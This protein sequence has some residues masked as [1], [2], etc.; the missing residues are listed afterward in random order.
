MAIAEL[1][2]ID[3][4][5]THPSSEKPCCAPN[6]VVITLSTTVAIPDYTRYYKSPILEF[7]PAYM[8]YNDGSL[9]LQPLV[10]AHHDSLLSILMT[11]VLVTLFVRNTLVCI[12]NLRRTTI[13]KKALFYAL[14]ISQILGIV[15]LAFAIYEQL[16]F[17]TRCKM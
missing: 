2:Q 13:Q 9:L 16:D 1:R 5:Q 8:A 7:A 14:L 6:E 4:E 17:L 10:D 11:G 15:A 3:V 12:V